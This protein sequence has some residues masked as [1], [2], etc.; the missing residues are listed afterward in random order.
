MRILTLVAFIVS[1]VNIMTDI[2]HFGKGKSKNKKN[3][4]NKK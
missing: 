4:K 1:L 3:N 2:L